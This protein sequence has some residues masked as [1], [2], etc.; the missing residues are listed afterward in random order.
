MNLQSI[1]EYRPGSGE[2]KWVVLFRTMYAE[3]PQ[4]PSAPT[5]MAAFPGLNSRFRNSPCHDLLEFP[6][7]H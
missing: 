3:T 1:H 4:S 2:R 7:H 6:V 5:Q